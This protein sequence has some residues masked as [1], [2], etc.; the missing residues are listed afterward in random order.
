MK[1]DDRHKFC[2]HYYINRASM[3]RAEMVRGQLHRRLDESWYRATTH[4][5]DPVRLSRGIRRCLVEGFFMQVAHVE[6]SGR[7]RT[8]K[9]EQDVDLHS[10]T[11]LP[12]KPPWVLYHEVMLTSR[13]FIRT[14]VRIEG[15]WLLELAGHYYDVNTFPES[16]AKTGL[17][18]IEEGVGEPG[19]AG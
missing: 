7:Y 17:K 1:N 15:E 5:S 19:G 13:N 18:N 3:E 12:D 4:H 9:D 11:S 8:V 14:V 16:E 2:R 10:S 6:T